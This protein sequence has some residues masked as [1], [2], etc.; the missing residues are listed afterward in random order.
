[1][2]VSSIHLSLLSCGEQLSIK[3]D[4]IEN[5]VMVVSNIYVNYS[6]DVGYTNTLCYARLYLHYLHLQA[7][8]KR[9]M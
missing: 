9:H 5:N 6:G 3:I 7:V 2:C 4:T 8:R 1:M